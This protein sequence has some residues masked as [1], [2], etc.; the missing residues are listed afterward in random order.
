M[1]MS[2]LAHAWQRS[3][4]SAQRREAWWESPCSSVTTTWTART[5]GSAAP[6][7]LDISAET[8]SMVSVVLFG[9]P[10]YGE[11]GAVRGPCL[12]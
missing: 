3:P 7:A 5:P 12:R 1:L 11:C 9:D 8:L 10:V 4:E 2:V 6:S